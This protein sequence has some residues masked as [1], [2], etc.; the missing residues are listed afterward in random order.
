MNALDK[1]REWIGTYPDFD[2]LSHF[3]VDYIDRVPATGG[4]YPAGLVEISRRSDIVG[5]VTVSNQYNF[6]LYYCFAKATEDDVDAEINADWISG[7]QEWVQEQSA[8]G[9]APVFGDVPNDERI[10][11][12]NG[13]L[14]EADDSGTATYMVQLSVQFKKKYEVENKWLI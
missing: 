9:Q 6:S 4:I 7:F 14:Y 2:I 10:S 8:T 12:Q 13:V 5:N 1:I 3:H 11:A